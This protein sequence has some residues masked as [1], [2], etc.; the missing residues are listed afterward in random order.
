MLPCM[1]VYSV[2]QSC[3]TLCEHMDCR[4]AGSSLHGISQARILEWVAM[5]PPGDLPNPGIE[6]APCALTDGF[7]TTEPPR[8]PQD[9]VNYWRGQRNLAGY[10]SWG[11]KEFDTTE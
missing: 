5:I 11:L 1:P 4:M 10:S 3:P 9:S 7:F 6:P 2:A 8:K